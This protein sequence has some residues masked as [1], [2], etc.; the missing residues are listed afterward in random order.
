LTRIRELEGRVAERGASA[1]A[2]WLLVAGLGV[3]LVAGVGGGFGWVWMK[4]RAHAIASAT[5][6]PAPESLNATWYP[7]APSFVDIDGD[8]T[9]EIVGLAWDAGHDAAAL[10]VVALDRTTYKVRWH[11]GP[12]TSQSSALTHLMIVDSRAVVVDSQGTVRILELINGREAARTTFPR[13]PVEEVCRVNDGTERVLL[14]DGRNWYDTQVQLL[15]VG[16]GAITPNAAHASCALGKEE[17]P[18]DATVSAPCMLMSPSASAGGSGETL[19][20]GDDRV[21][22]SPSPGDE[23]RL[24]GAGFSNRS[25]TKRWELPLAAP[26]DTPHAHSACGVTGLGNGGV[27]HV[28]QTSTG[29]LRMTGRSASNGAQTFAVDLPETGEGSVVSSV[30]V[31]GDEVFV[32]VN[33]SLRI[34]DAKNGTAI[35]TIGRL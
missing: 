35:R 2:A 31:N 28:Y 3:L 25:R 18:C 19:A 8:G 6:A 4:S 24:V 26:G 12:Y 29:Q 20:H 22:V 14:N 30:S 1:T 32:V 23:C 16:T 9:H 7:R 10:H 34:F 27:F 17:A 5:A 33:Q 21:T 15:D 11:A 13:G